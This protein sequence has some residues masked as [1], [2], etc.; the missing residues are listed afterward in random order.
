MSKKSSHSKNPFDAYHTISKIMD[1]RS[2]HLARI[3]EIE[4]DFNERLDPLTQK[5]F[6]LFEKA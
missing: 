1:A 3:E 5:L 2:N 6:E 4:N